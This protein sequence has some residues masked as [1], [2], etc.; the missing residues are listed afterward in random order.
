MSPGASG[1]RKHSEG[2]LAQNLW[3]QPR[4]SCSPGRISRAAEQ[5]VQ[6]KDPRSLRGCQ[7][8]SQ[9]AC[10]GGCQR[11]L[12][13]YL[14]SPPNTAVGHRMTCLIQGSHT[15]LRRKDTHVAGLPDPDRA[16]QL[17]NPVHSGLRAAQSPHQLLQQVVLQVLQTWGSLPVYPAPGSSPSPSPSHAL[18][19]PQL[20]LSSGG[21]VSSPCW[22]LRL[23]TAA[24][25]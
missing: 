22:I 25:V 16:W 19:L 5:W 18:L 14:L 4:S 11:S 17:R 15:P 21:H 6:R 20:T 8:V 1:R 9:R 3:P 2:T 13:W 23:R 24:T 12:L 10:L 7:A